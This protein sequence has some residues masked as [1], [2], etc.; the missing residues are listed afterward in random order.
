MALIHLRQPG[1][2]VANFS[3]DGTTITV[4]GVAIDCAARQ[5]DMLTIIEIR[6]NSGVASEGGAGA[7]LAHIEIPAKTYHDEVTPGG[8]GEEDTITRVADALHPDA[9]SVTLWPAAAA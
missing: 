7:Y 2:P 4:E 6:R 8:D 5:Q 9:I 3:T 1:Q